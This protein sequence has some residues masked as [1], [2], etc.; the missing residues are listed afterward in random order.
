LSANNY[1][2]QIKVI[3]ECTYLVEVMTIKELNIKGTLFK[4]LDSQK[5][6]PAC[7]KSLSKHPN[8]SHVKFLLARSY[9]KAKQYKKSLKL[10]KEAC[11][12]GDIGACTLLGSLYAQAMAGVKYNDKIANMLFFW[13]CTQGDGQACTNLAM[14]MRQH[15]E[16][17][18]HDKSINKKNLLLKGCLSHYYPNA[19]TVY[20]NNMYFK[21]IPYNEDLFIYTNYKSCISGN[22]NA[23]DRLDSV[24]NK[25]KAKIASTKNRM[26]YYKQSCNNGNPKACEEVGMIYMKK[27][28]NRVNNIMAY[29]FF[30]DGCENGAERFSCWFAGRYKLARLEGIEYDI[31]LGIK[32]MEKACYIGMNSFACYD[33]A[34]F[35]LEMPIKKYRNDTKIHQLFTRAC[36]V[37]NR[38]A[39][40]LG[41]SNDVEFCCKELEEYKKYKQTQKTQTN[42]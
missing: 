26:M 15:T 13:G 9:L 18:P 16:Y 4:D 17:M 41:C 31:P 35:L 14:Q 6:I 24:S 21:G 7:K 39:L 33:L 20:S 1:I 32:Y 34:K 36:R 38:R 2:R 40:Y 8:N 29:S 28:R 23:C 12:D 3:D 19:C 42:R 27:P 11:F 37:G 22:D 5:A 25:L 30:K 10:T